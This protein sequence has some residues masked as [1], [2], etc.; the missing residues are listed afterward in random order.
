MA[1]LSISRLLEASKLL[2]TKAGQELTDLIEYTNDFADQT[3]RALRQGLTLR[4]N[5]KCELVTATLKDGVAQA[6]N[7]NGQTI[8]N[9]QVLRV[10]STLYG[11]ASI[12]WYKDDSN[13][14]IVKVGFTGSPTTEL[15]VNLAIF[16]E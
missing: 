10:Y 4:D 9:V 15:S 8:N 7:Y 2:A 1:K 13:K 14:L 16:Y 11:V 3:L 6:I 5:F 12:L